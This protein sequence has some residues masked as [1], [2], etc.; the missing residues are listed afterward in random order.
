MVRLTIPVLVATIK[1]GDGPSSWEKYPDLVTTKNARNVYRSPFKKI[2]LSQKRLEVSPGLL[3]N[4]HWSDLNCGR[5]FPS[6][7]G[8]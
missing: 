7:V 5:L 8:L 4:I 2:L 1:D 3:K 6:L